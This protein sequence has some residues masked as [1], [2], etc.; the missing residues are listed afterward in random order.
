MRLLS[1]IFALAFLSFSSNAQQNLTAETLMQFERV[2]GEKI[3]PDGSSITYNVR[4]YDLKSNKGNTDIYRI[5]TSGGNMIRLAGSPNNEWGAQWRPDGNRIGYLTTVK[6]STQI[7]EMDKDGSN[8]TQLSSF[9]GSITNFGYSPKGGYVWF[10]SDV[11]MDKTAAEMHPD[12]P[13]VKARVSDGLMVRHWNQWHDYAYSHL[14]IQKINNG[15]T[16][17]TPKDVMKGERFD[18]PLNPF[19][20]A[21]HIAFSYDEKYVA[22][23]CKKLHGTAYTKS[24]NS[25]IYLYDI[26][27]EQTE[28]LSMGMEGYDVN[29]VFSPDGKKLM[30]LSME[31]PGYESDRNRM[32]IYDLSF[33]K[34]EVDVIPN[35]DYSISSASFGSNSNETFFI[36]SKEA[37]YQIFT[38]S[39]NKKNKKPLR[40][41]TN[42]TANIRSF[43][44]AK[45]RKGTVM[46]AS[47]QNMSKPTEVYK[48]DLST[49]ALNKITKVNDPLLSRIKMG[50]VEK[51]MIKTS[52][53]QDMLTWVIYPPNFDP[54]KKYPTLLYC[55]GG[56]Q[57]PVSQ[58]FSYRWNFQMMAANGYIVVAPN[59][60]GLPS[61]GEKW[62]DDIKGDW[63]GQ[64]M[65]DLLSAIDEVAKEPFVDRDKL[66]A[67][68]AS[69]GGYS[70]FWLAGNH[71]KR[72]KSFIAHC[73]VFNLESMYGSTEETFF[74]NQDMDGAYWDKPKPVSYTK[75]SPHTYVENWDT[76]ILVIHNEKDYRVPL[77]QGLEAFTAAQLLGVQSRLLYF[78]DEG[79]WVGKPQNAVLWQR[80]FFAWLDKYLK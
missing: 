76:P 8:K 26:H 54:K 46:I 29:P 63:G 52:D 16:I 2:S 39:L 17:G 22:Y 58:F 15:N 41:I 48:V 71:N 51:R 3:S 4:A 12:L 74:V 35:F 60:R 57:S 11:K 42:E 49:G 47:M 53:N 21:E 65:K 9:K 40:Q 70:V 69:F 28:N 36:A 18:T 33:K 1:L 24:T 73:G 45:T 44:L 75:H 37:T 27:T 72:F 66:G 67:V 64:A 14:F 68:G 56:P 80:E 32:V 55:Q 50:K 43:D 5:N 62:N 77:T 34:K 19:G 20:G 23:T 25:D 6:G 79:H 61:F 10:T 38:F 78:P 13:E 30:W 7:W 59:R 31:T